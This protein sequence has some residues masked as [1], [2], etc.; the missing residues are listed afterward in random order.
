MYFKTP[1]NRTHG[2]CRSVVSGPSSSIVEDLEFSVTN[3]VFSIWAGSHFRAL[4]RKC[5]R[6]KYDP[7]LEFRPCDVPLFSSISDL[8][9]PTRGLS[10]AQHSAPFIAIDQAASITVVRL[11]LRVSR[12]G[13]RFDCGATRDT[14]CVR[15]IGVDR[16]AAVI[17]RSGQSTQSRTVAHQ[18]R[19]RLTKDPM[20]CRWPRRS[21]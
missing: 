6:F 1:S 19:S 10:S 15:P 17:A 12:V 21:N 13:C 3:K 9:V 14:D 2:L 16:D 4:F 11:D 5:L 7:L 8:N 20:V 18:C